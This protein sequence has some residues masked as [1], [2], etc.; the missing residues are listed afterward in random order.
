[1]HRF[2][3]VH[4][5]CFVSD[6]DGDQLVELHLID[7]MMPAERMAA[8]FKYAGNIKHAIYANIICICT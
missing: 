5:E 6:M 3:I 4:I 8:K 1:M 7:P 2:N